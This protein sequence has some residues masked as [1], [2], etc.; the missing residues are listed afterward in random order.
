MPIKVH[1]LPPQLIPS[2]ELLDKMSKYKNEIANDNFTH[3]IDLS[4]LTK[5]L[6]NHGKD[7]ARKM[8]FK[9]RRWREDFY[10]AVQIR[11][12]CVYQLAAFKCLQRPSE[13]CK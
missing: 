4:R 1:K 8:I 5:T 7:L 10:T 6:G 12:S 11:G 9:Q 2:Q 13:T 3:A